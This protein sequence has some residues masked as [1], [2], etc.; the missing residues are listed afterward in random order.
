[1][2]SELVQQIRLRIEQAEQILITSHARPDGDSIGSTLGLG[3]A[4]AQTGKNIE[5]VSADGVPAALKFLPGSEK[6]KNHATIT[7]DLVI[8][9]DSG[10]LDRV[11]NVLDG[12]DRIDIN[13]D[14]HPDNTF[15]AEFNL[16]QS[17]AVS[18]TEILSKLIPELEIEITV[19]VAANLLTGLI[20]DTIGFKTENMHPGAFRTAAQMVELGADLPTLYHHAIS[21][22]TFEAARYMGAGLSQLSRQD[23]LVYTSLTLEN[24]KQAQYPGRDDA[25]LVNILSSISDAKIALIFIE[26]SDGSVK[27]SWRTRSPKINVSAI[28]HQF[29]G[30]GHRA[31]AGAM[32]AGTLQEVQ[33][34]VITATHNV[35]NL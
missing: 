23:G 9:L 12:Y 24:R 2:N 30:G 14:H 20:T 16:V 11:G 1:M 33:E 34:K 32:V 6:I 17:D 35:L 25:D 15:F 5:L 26:Q 27:I 3:L 19:D 7:A 13:I 8:V 22:K 4:L 31:A 29:G 28:A 10:N 18:T 21:E